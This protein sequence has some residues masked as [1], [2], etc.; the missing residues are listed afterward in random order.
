[1]EI[2]E[3]RIKAAGVE[4]TEIAKEF[5]T[6]VYVYDGE[7]ILQQIRSLKESFSGVDLKIKYAV[8][9]LSNISILKVIKKG[10]AELDAVSIQEGRMGMLAGFEPAQILFTPNSVDFSEIE[11]AVTLGFFVNIDNL[12]ILEQFGAKYGSRVPCCL[13]LNPHIMAGG[14]IKISTG[15]ENS[16][17][18]ISFKKLPEIREIVKKYNISLKGL[19]LH[20]G[21][22]I[23]DTDVF[24]EGLKV[25][26]Q[27]ASEFK[28]L[29]F[30]DIG[31]GF[32]V[33]YK[34]YDKVTDVAAVGKKVSEALQ[35]FSRSYGK[36][37]QLWIEPG[38]YLVSE[39]GYLLVKANV[40]KESG[41]VTFVGVNSG[42]NHLIRPMMY[43][44]YHE[45][46]NLSN[47]NGEVKEY[48]VVGYI[49]ETDTFGMAREINEIRPGDILAFK[50][51]GAYGFSM[52]SNYNSR[53]RP[54]EILVMNGK[55]Q[56]IRKSEDFED[57]VRK[58]VIVDL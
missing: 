16:K 58:Q 19:H 6:P 4:L 52:S 55:A 7:K 49:C 1:M 9:A 25:L 2:V 30:L 23:V 57:L 20:T 56:V 24:V 28:G 8:K 29:D 42:M 44:A 14:N 36:K 45:I 13:R 35:E 10:G 41:N 53:F 32:K 33:A 40:L 12:D 50:N 31:S 48:A 39:S 51:G 21:S 17:F 11:E 46:I 43:E 18:G 54:A 26:F 47:T 22:D 37:L 27:M 34:S 15:Y 3:N 38:K 5:G